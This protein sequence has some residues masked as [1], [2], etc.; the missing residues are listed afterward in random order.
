[1]LNQYDHVHA[2]NEKSIFTCMNNSVGFEYIV[3]R[4]LTVPGLVR[5]CRYNQFNLDFH[6]NLMMTQSPTFAISNAL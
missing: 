2:L 4:R 5:D 6:W 3:V 1:M